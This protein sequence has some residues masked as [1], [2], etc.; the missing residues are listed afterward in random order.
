M[1]YSEI[2]FLVKRVYLFENEALEIYTE[3]KSYLF[4]FESEKERNFLLKYFY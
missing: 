3:T 4:E 2:K 1:K